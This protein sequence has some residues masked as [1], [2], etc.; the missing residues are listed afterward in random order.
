VWA[1]WC[2]LCREEMG[3]LEALHEEFAPADSGWSG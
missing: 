1:T 3:D 2:T